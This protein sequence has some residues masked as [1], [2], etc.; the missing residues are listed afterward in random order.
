MCSNR[1]KYIHRSNFICIPQLK[2]LLLNR[3]RI[4][5]IEK[6]LFRSLSSLVV[7]DLSHNNIININNFAFY[8]LQN[9]KFLNLKETNILYMGD[10]IFESARIYFLLADDFHLCCLSKTSHTMC[11]PLPKWPSSCNSLFANQIVTVSSWCMA[12]SV[13]ILNIISILGNGY[14]CFRMKTAK[15][16]LYIILI[17]MCDLLI[18]LYLLIICS[19]Y[20]NMGEKYVQ[21]DIL[22]RSS[23]ICNITGFLYTLAIF[24]SAFF[25]VAVGRMRYMI[26]K[27]PL[28]KSASTSPT[29]ITVIFVPCLFAILLLI[30]TYIRREVENFPKLP[31][32]LCIILGSNDGSVSEKVLTIFIAIYLLINFV[33][34]LILYSKLLILIHRASDMLT[35]SRQKE[36]QTIVT[37]NILLTG[38]CNALCW[39]PS[40]IF[41]FITIS[42]DTLP[43]NLLYWMTFF[44]VPMNSSLNPIIFSIPKLAKI[45]RY[46][47]DF[48]RKHLY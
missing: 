9:V 13:F 29:M 47:K 17:N 2:K 27:Y 38:V 32:P 36:R 28:Q 4:T 24:L 45:S 34:V 16:E 14:Y 3:N 25:M 7:L 43:V 21:G 42:V 18:G 10:K 12:A 41:Y 39:L 31:S 33:M 48:K 15:F 1:I 26:L 8:N 37:Q 30:V 40:S 5:I 23:L 6:Y 11:T 19:A 22:W 35:Q 46:V 20:T 44:I